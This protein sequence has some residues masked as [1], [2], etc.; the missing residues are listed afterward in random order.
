[1]GRTEP[2]RR[3][4]AIVLGMGTGHCGLRLLARILG[5]QPD[6]LVTHEQPPLLSWELRTGDAGVQQRLER[7]LATR[8]RMARSM[9]LPQ[10]FPSW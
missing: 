3:D 4:R 5:S 2:K 7:L 1:M 8:P 9:A 6:A 10:P